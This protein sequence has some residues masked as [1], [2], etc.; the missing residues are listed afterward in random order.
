MKTGGWL[1]RQLFLHI[2]SRGPWRFPSGASRVLPLAFFLSASPVLLA[3]NLTD[4]NQPPEIMR[5]F[6]IHH[7]T[8]ENWLNDDY[9]GL[10]LALRDHNYF[11]SDSNYGW[12]PDGIGDTTDIGHWYR[13]FRSPESPGYMAA[14][15]SASDQNCSYT[16]WP[17]T[18]EGS[19][20][21]ILFKSCFPNSALQGNPGD[22]IPPIA[23]NPLCDQDA[24]S[25]DH[26][27]A[28]AKGIYRDLLNFFAAN[29]NQLFVAITAPPLSDSTYA[30]NARAFNQWLVSDWL[31][32][33]PHA[34]VFV[35]DFYNVLTSNHGSPSASDVN[36]A[37][38]NH[39]RWRNGAAEHTVNVLSNVSAYASAAGDD[40]PNAVGS[41]KATVEFVPLLNAAVN[42]W[43]K[44]LE[45]V[46]KRPCF[47]SATLS[48]Q[49]V[50][51]TI[52]D[53]TP[54]AV[55]VLQRSTNLSANGWCNIATF[56]NLGSTN[57]SEPALPTPGGVFYR[58]K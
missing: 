54:G 50:A 38:G 16:R 46:P 43:K 25:D 56:T 37:T 48:Q 49:T 7:S 47:V 4:T 22:P 33:Y 24:W 17:D 13:W 40:H 11:V 35:F 18:P 42:A 34:N 31:A 21:I 27:V 57:W 9:G 14:V 52:A 26:T 6:F 55:Q 12:G 29:T 41:R 10:G 28:N 39:H 51:F 19:N 3:A 1:K 20:Q 2:C 30:N 53:L 23:S 36:L 45:S 44:S 8:G 5:L 32:N 15:Y 58:I